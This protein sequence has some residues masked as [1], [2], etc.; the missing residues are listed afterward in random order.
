[1]FPIPIELVI[2]FFV[3]LS[4]FVFALGVTFALLLNRLLGTPA[5]QYLVSSGI[6][7]VASYSVATLILLYTLSPLCW[8]NEQPQDLRT[9]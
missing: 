8:V 1:M 3:L 7:A 2:F 6:I 5:K 4:G 9:A